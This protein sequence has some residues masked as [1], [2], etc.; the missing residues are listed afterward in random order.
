MS[1]VAKT[2]IAL[3]AACLGAAV[4]SSPVTARDLGIEGQIYEPIEEDFRVHLMRLVARQ[5]WEPSQEQLKESAENYT[6]NLPDYFIPVAKETK[7]TWK[8]VGV[9]V[10]EDI[11][12]P[13]VDWETGSVFEPQPVLVAEKGTYFNPIAK[14]PA[15]GIE[16]LFI[17]DSTDPEQLSLARALMV[18]QIPNLHFMVSAGDLGPIAK[19]MN[20][21]IFHPTAGMIE[22]FHVT[23][24]PTLIGFGRGAHQGHLAVTHFSLPTSIEEVKSAWFGLPYP[25][26]D[27]NSYQDVIPVGDGAQKQPAG[28]A[29]AQQPAD[30]DTPSQ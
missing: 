5:D 20:R 8:D 29:T 15:A 11:Y 2:R 24:V 21:P 7:T 13:S 16:R 22:K 30:F 17:F 28:G 12:L 10:T 6:K 23:A 26:Y 3:A 27:P 18:Q 19:E 4:L 1:L 14:L 9:V 25:G